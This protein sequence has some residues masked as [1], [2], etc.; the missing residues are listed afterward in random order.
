M[1]PEE[2][3]FWLDVLHSP[4]AI[5]IAGG[6]AGSLITLVVTVLKNRHE[7]KENEKKWQRE[8]ERRKEERAFEKKTATYENF[9]KCF[10]DIQNNNLISFYGKFTPIAMN[11]MT[12][13]NLEVKI[14]TRKSYE[15]MLELILNPQ[16]KLE[17]SPQFKDLR[18]HCNEI[19]T[20]IMKDVDLHFSRN[21][22]EVWEKLLRSAENK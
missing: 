22:I 7:S 17:D 20:A 16:L 6:L 4:A 19:H 1:T 18:Y 3:K 9:F 8:E 13:G 12:Y 5:A 21:D 11:L 10:E 15:I 14:H 2:M